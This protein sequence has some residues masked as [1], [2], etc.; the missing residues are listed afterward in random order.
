MNQHTAVLCS[1]GNDS[2]DMSLLNLWDAPA[3]VVVAQPDFLGTQPADHSFGSQSKHRD[4]SQALSDSAFFSQEP[5]GDMPRLVIPL[6]LLCGRFKCSDQMSSTSVFHYTACRRTSMPGTTFQSPWSVSVGLG[7]CIRFSGTEFPARGPQMA[8]C[9]RNCQGALVLVMDQGLPLMQCWN[10]IQ[11]SS[12]RCFYHMMQA[13]DKLR[14]KPRYDYLV[15]AGLG[16]TVT[17]WRQRCPE[18]RKR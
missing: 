6:N 16:V 7:E 13:S 15:H 11:E 4:L 5:P 14:R 18:R 8:R 9:A 1:Q 10:D 2:A 3:C 12:V 17:P